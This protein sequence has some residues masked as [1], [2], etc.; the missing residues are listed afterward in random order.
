MGR[1]PSLYVFMFMICL[2]V[3]VTAKD[4]EAFDAFYEQFKEEFPVNDMGDL[5]WYLGA[6]S[7][8]T[9]WRAL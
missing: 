7:S 5:F 8:V 9:R 2:T 4:K 1:L 3:T 6:R